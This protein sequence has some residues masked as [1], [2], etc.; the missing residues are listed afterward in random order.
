MNNKIKK[1]GVL[2]M[3]LMLI[4]SSFGNLGTVFAEDTPKEINW[5]TNPETAIDDQYVKF[6]DEGL[7]NIMLMYLDT[8][9][10]IDKNKKFKDQI[11]VGEA[12]KFKPGREG[13]FLFY[14]HNSNLTEITTE[15]NSWVGMEYFKNL[16]SIEIKDPDNKMNKMSTNLTPFKNLSN[17]GTFVFQRQNDTEA[18]KATIPEKLIDVNQFIFGENEV[19]AYLELNKT[20]DLVFY[21]PTANAHNREDYENFK[22]LTIKEAYDYFQNKNI[23]DNTNFTKEYSG[24]LVYMNGS[25]ITDIEKLK[26]VSFGEQGWFNYNHIADI[27]PLE[28]NNK[29]PTLKFEGQ[30]I[31][32]KPTEKTYELPIKTLNNKNIKYS[33]SPLN[34]YVFDPETGG[35]EEADIPE[36]AKP[37][38]KNGTLT[39]NKKTEKPIAIDFEYT[40]NDK[41]V[42]YDPELAKHI[43]HKKIKDGL[44]YEDDFEKHLKYII[45]KTYGEID[46]SGK[47]VKPHKRDIKFN[48]TIVVDPSDIKWDADLFTP[49]TKSITKLVGQKVADNEYKGAITNLPENLDKFEVITPAN[50]DTIGDKTAVVRLTFEDNSTKDVEITVKVRT[51]AGMVDDEIGKG[52]VSAEKEIVPWGGE[53]DLTDNIVGNIKDMGVTK[54]TDVT[55][56]KID[57]KVSG[58][59]TGK[60]KLEFDDGSEL[61]VDVPVEVLTK[62]EDPKKNA[63][64]YNPEG[65]DLNVNIGDEP[66]A[67]DAI[68]N[69]KD[70]PKNTKYEWKE[71]PDTKEAGKKD[72]TVIVTYPD[73]SKDEVNINI[74][75]VYPK[76]DAEKN[77]VVKPNKT[78]VEDKNNLTPEEKAKVSEEVK[79]VNPEAKDIE[80]KDNG[81]TVITYPDGSTNNLSQEDTVIEKAKEDIPLTPLTPAEEDIPLTPLTP[82]EE[83]EKPAEPKK[84]YSREPKVD[85]IYDGDTKITG[86]GEPRSEIEIRLPNRKTVF[87]KT[88]REGYFEID[89]KIKLYE[90]EK[91]Y[92]TQIE[93]GKEPS[94]EITETVR[95]ARGHRN[96]KN[97]VKNTT[98]TSDVVG[99]L[100]SVKEKLITSDHSSY[101]VGYPDGNFGPNNT[102]TRAEVATIFARLSKDQSTRA[103]LAFKDVKNT[104]WF[105]KAVKIG[106]SQGFI[107]G[108]NDGTFKPN[109]PITRAEFASV[110]STYANKTA[111]TNA[112]ND[113]NG[114]S[115]RAIDTAYANGWMQGNAGQFRPNDPLTRAEAVTVINRMLNRQADRAFIA[116][117]INSHAARAYKDINSSQWY[118]YDVYAASWGH[119][120]TIENGVEKWTGLNGKAFTIR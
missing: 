104:D 106:V 13:S 76:T 99:V 5:A 41:D 102:I 30:S 31:I 18:K 64:K 66:K 27:T 84:D 46:D 74:T 116:N 2:F 20:G 111:S 14:P 86:K 112:F 39:I 42:E 72:A 91:V 22:K 1:I 19:R 45:E 110:I 93:Y 75:V 43:T 38:I 8:E 103:N 6:E 62:P 89:T 78:E 108:Y 114:W 107:N 47:I 25:E 118:F 53:Y 85:P 35:M 23:L 36:E 115:V 68:N 109:K 24:N 96:K 71:T 80:V 120:Y 32:V 40:S 4:V 52:D 60:V 81:D 90:D 73:G 37:V 21:V 97:D 65:R 44:D 16:R 55:D 48:G 51:R 82:S 56:P 12:R 88:D 26:G 61:V 105:N 63:D 17:I 119:N 57:T 54:I 67:E 29:I 49:E 79:K 100:N 98:S 50:T 10:A 94:K 34:Y 11:T 9:S 58:N 3:A 95:R 92:V 101:I 113:V 59:H 33:L 117:A 69:K 77:P 70:L 7:K 15:I 83:I 87:G 28:E